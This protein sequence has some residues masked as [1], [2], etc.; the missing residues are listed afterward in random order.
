LAWALVSDRRDGNGHRQECQAGRAGSSCYSRRSHR[1]G[2]PHAE[3]GK[4]GEAAAIGLGSFALGSALGAGA[5]NP[6]GGYY[7]G[8][9]Y[10][11]G[12]YYPAPAAPAYYPPPTPYYTPRS[13]WDSYYRRYYAC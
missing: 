5:A 1:G 10:P 7:G 2:V 3:S 12:G 4:G 11:Y 6:Y 8:Y 9:A 13:C